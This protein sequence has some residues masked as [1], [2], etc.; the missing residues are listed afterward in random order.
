MI[1]ILQQ[2]D[3]L[4]F[5]SA[6]KDIVLWADSDVEVIFT[7][8]TDDGFLSEVYTPDRDGKIYIR[9]LGKLLGNYIP[10]TSLRQYFEI[11]M[12]SGYDGAVVETTVLYCKAELDITAADFL[13]NRFLTLLPE[14]KITYAGATEFLSLY[15]SEAETLTIKARRL[16][17]EIETKTLAIDAVN[18]ITT[19]DASPAALFDAPE[20]ISYY[21][22]TAGARNMTFYIK[23][24][25]PPEYTQFVF[26]NSFGV[27]ETFIPAA[28]TTRENKY[29]NKTGYF[30][31]KYRRYFSEVVKTFTANT[32]ILTGGMADWIEDLFLS[33]DVYQLTGAGVEKEIVIEEST[34]KRSTAQDELPAFEFKYRLSKLNHHECSLKKNRI[35]DG[36]FDYTHN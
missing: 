2:P 14:E 10:K 31:G 26:L 35:F 9:D 28:I 20:E 25:L 12:M 30:S 7:T 29:E 23:P 24:E 17:G 22:L 18:A 19:V 4:C 33:R 36:T 6:V 11:W 34:V 13:P 32:G 5:S 27:K 8:G 15:T 3:S 16:S 21:V 1:L